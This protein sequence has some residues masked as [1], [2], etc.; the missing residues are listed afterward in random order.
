MH[1][2]TRV[3]KGKI[4]KAM[5][6]VTLGVSLSFGGLGPV[7]SSAA[8][9]S[10][11]VTNL[12][13]NYTETPLGI[14]EETPSFSWQMKAPAHSRGYSQ[15]AYQL[16]VKDKDGRVVWNTKKVNSGES[17]NIRYNGEDLQ[18][19]TRYRWEVTV[20][21]QRGKTTK[22]ASWFE[23]GLM[24]PDL[25]AWDG[26]TW[27]GGGDDDLVLKADYFNVFRINYSLQLDESSKSTKASFVLGA[28]DPRLM[29]ANKNIRGV[30]NGE[31]ESYIKFE[32][33]TSA[34]DGSETGLAKFHIYRVGYTKDDSADKPLLSYDI[35]LNLINDSNKY[36]KHDFYV[37]S[38][39]GIVSVSLD[40]TSDKHKIVKGESSG[41]GA[42]GGVNINP[43][44]SGGNY[45][46][47]PMVGDIG[48]SI[49]SNQ[50][51]SF[52]NV[53]V[54]NLRSPHNTLFKE[55]LSVTEYN[56]IFAEEKAAG[57]EIENQ[58]Y[59]VN[60]GKKDTFVVADPSNNSMPMLRTEFDTSDKKIES[61]RLYATARGIYEIYLNGERVSDYYFA[62]GLT[63]YNESHQYQTYDV[64]DFVKSGKTNAI[65][66]M[67]GEGWW[68]GAITFTTSRWNHFG[69]RQ[70]LLA[71]LV[72]T[73][74]D[75][76]T[77][78]VTT[79]P[80]DWKYYDE[81]PV[82]YGSFFQ[83][84][85]YDA[86]KDDEI[87]NWSKASYD[88]RNW[89]ASEVVPLDE[90]TTPNDNGLSYE[91]MELIGQIGEPPSVVTT[92]T[93]KS[94]T[95]VRDG[96]FVY[97]MGQNAVGVPQITL[98]DANAG[99]KITL[100]VAEMLY[101]DLD[102]SGDNV[103]M[104]MMEN[105]RA[106]HVTD[107]YITKEGDQ[108]IEPRFTFHGY[109][110]LEI[111]GIDKALPLEA[112]KTQVISSVKELSSSYKTSNK[113]VNKLFENITWSM[114][115]NSYPFRL[116]HQPVTNVWGGEETFLFLLEPLLI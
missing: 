31:D 5:F 77:E 61:A 98:D 64:T 6:A 112:V 62:P 107:T 20:W 96:V 34:V 24:N 82:V 110:Y 46:S 113:Q 13:V 70:S 47:Y 18:P 73:Y 12:K 39:A 90:T 87:T 11:D 36:E 52:T 104:I 57:L 37:S 30:E 32:L 38:D 66:A 71:K 60:G 91:D 78:V 85:F 4:S 74:D 9:S 14:D 29:D 2:A 25:S 86:T 1:K 68:S 8:A 21:D 7:A 102:E 101:P 67:L 79:N 108:V 111:T 63:Q 106:A 116:I 49:D 105:L 100:R 83:G 53:E 114:R 65:G 76:S 99:K 69:D 54:I 72:I 55:D 51:A 84:E 109:R 42:P 41:P 35:P 26:A 97:D 27:I 10:T 92:L 94:V 80:D 15:K 81:G 95:E 19:S 59:V 115:G 45:I 75:G 93:A 33:D 56:G 58:A 89:E 50:K 17:L 3:S 22:E 88:D 16:K 48:F 103:D 44:G 40:G 43:V 23:T 28:N